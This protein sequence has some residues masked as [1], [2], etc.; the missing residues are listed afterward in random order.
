M[1]S[2]EKSSKSDQTTKARLAALPT[3]AHETNP[4][5][6]F[7]VDEELAHGGLTYH[8]VWT[9]MVGSQSL[10]F[11]RGRQVKDFSNQDWAHRFIEVLSA[12]S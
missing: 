5:S 8:L 1:A 12:R 3:L 11:R 10:I 2:H 7:T 9:H 4:V 6:V